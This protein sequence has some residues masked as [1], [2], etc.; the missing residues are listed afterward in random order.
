MAQMNLYI[1]QKQTYRHRGET[2]GCQWVG[3]ESGV[4]GEFRVGRYKLLHLECVSNEV[5]IY[6]T[7]EKNFVLSSIMVYPGP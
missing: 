1:K 3:G 6:V 2:C 5:L 4:D 7:G